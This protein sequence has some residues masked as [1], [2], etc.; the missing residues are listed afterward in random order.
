MK[1]LQDLW[2]ETQAHAWA[3]DQHTLLRY[4]SNLLGAD[5]RITNFGGGNTSAKFELPDPFTGK[6]VRVLGVKGSGGDL[7]TAK[8]KGFALI[9]LD[10]FDDLRRLYKG[11]DHEDE[12]VAY[13]TQASFGAATVAPSID[14][15]LHALLPFAH[16]DHLHPDW[17]IALAAAANGKQKMEEFNQRF[18]HHLVWLPWQRPGFD[19]ALRLREAVDGN[20]ACDGIVLGGHGLFTWGDTARQCYLNSVTMI[21][22]LG[23]FVGEHLEKRG[24][25]LFGGGQSRR[26]K[27]SRE[28]S[29][30]LFPYLRGRLATTRRAIAHF[31]NSDEVLQFV[32]SKDATALAHL[33]TS[34]P[35]HFVRTRIRPLYIHWNPDSETLPKLKDRITEEAEKYRQEYAGYYHRFA[36]KDSPSLRDANPS[37]V[38]IPGL[39]MFTFGKNKTEARITSEFYVNAIH[40]MAGAT[41]LGEGQAPPTLLPQAPKPE[42]SKEFSSHDNYVALPLAEAFRIEY[43]ALEEAKLR[44]Q[45]PEKEYS[46]KIFLVVGGGSGIGRVTVQRLVEG[47]AH[48]MVADRDELAAADSATTAGKS[49][50]EAVASCKMDLGDRASIAT[51]VHETVLRFGGL[52]GIINTAAIF[53]PP[54]T[55]GRLTDE[56]WRRTFDINI[57]GNYMLVD[58]GRPHL[59]AQG[60]PAV[61]VLTSSANAVVPKWGSEAYD[62]SKSAVSHLVREMAVGL[63]PLVRVNGVSPATVVEGSTMFPR[64]RVLISLK[65]FHVAFSEEESTEDLRSKL[66]NFYAHRTLTKQSVTPQD[67]AEAICWLASDRAARTTGHLIPVDGGLVEAFLR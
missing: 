26:R 38:L 9:Y 28:I 14:T 6:P 22:D 27:D 56:N 42:D 48:V 16:V 41:A 52:D 55:R 32:N 47:G 20:P 17:G 53:I 50:K 10:R 60:L 65:K 12:M 62:I 7:G 1:Y 19:L 25:G 40:V 24:A 5:L 21:D 2:D 33:G 8:N 61:I 43:W 66:A 54:D 36:T 57:S 34:C 3:D 58:E 39:G 45:P 44:R 35:D 67:C 59:L 15:P 30:E 64:E 63:A 13:Y 31:N 49:A 18:H 23:V 46:R 11:R 37:V 29:I 51:A 4:R